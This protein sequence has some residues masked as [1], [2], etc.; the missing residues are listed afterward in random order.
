MTI[1]NK[2]DIEK[3]LNEFENWANYDANGKKHYFV[4]P[5]AKRNGFWTMMKYADGVF[6]LHG[7]GE[8]YCDQGEKVLKKEELQTIVWNNRR[9]VNEAL[10]KQVQRV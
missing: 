4:F 9:F 2:R 7:K 6:T 5:D 8:T 1:R 3:R 10:K